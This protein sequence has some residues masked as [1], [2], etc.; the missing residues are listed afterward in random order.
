[1][2]F[3]IGSKAP[4]SLCVY[5]SNLSFDCNWQDLKT[6]FQSKLMDVPYVEPMYQNNGTPNGKAVIELGSTELVDKAVTH[7]DGFLYKNRKLRVKKD[8]NEM[9]HRYFLCKDVNL[10]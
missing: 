5:V 2:F 9:D 8:R 4:P 1:M 6:L 7:F 3:K 10:C